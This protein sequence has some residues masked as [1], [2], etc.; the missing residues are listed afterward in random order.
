MLRI[1]PPFYHLNINLYLY[2]ITWKRISISYSVPRKPQSF[3]TL[4]SEVIKGVIPSS[5]LESIHSEHLHFVKALMNGSE[6][7]VNAFQVVQEAPMEPAKVLQVLFQGEG[8]ELLRGE[9]ESLCKLSGTK[10]ITQPLTLKIKR[11]AKWI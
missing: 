1:S 3:P 10:I 4:F 7:S 11:K 5:A 8:K 2:P 6:I 9:I